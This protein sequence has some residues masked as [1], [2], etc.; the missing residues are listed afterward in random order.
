M[1]VQ[2][3]HSSRIFAKSLPKDALFGGKDRFG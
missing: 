1:Q 3:G 2:I